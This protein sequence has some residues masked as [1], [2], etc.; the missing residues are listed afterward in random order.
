[1]LTGGRFWER[2]IIENMRMTNRLVV[3]ALAAAVTWTSVEAG[4]DKAQTI[5][6][7]KAITGLPRAEYAAKASELV[8]KAQDA[9][10]LETAVAA[11]KAAMAKAPATAPV[12][13]A[14]I[15]QIAPETAPAIAAAATKFSP[16]QADMIA[17]AAAM[18][19]PKQAAKIVMA[20][21]QAA[22]DACGPVLLAVMRVVPDIVSLPSSTTRTRANQSLAGG[23]GLIQTLRVPL[24]AISIVP[25]PG[26][27]VIS[28]NESL[29]SEIA[30][31]RDAVGIPAAPA[32]TEGG[33]EEFRASP[34]LP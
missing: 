12:I 21:S 18:A 27:F 5:A 8:S 29:A 1:M 6:I 3:A 17:K 33:D 26:G 20:V 22:P 2:L 32:Q 25:I 16:T 19:A 31:I 4:L 7:G 11:L 13:V 9:D 10:K 30:S 14:A 34:P 24:Q 28:V 15:A 23:V